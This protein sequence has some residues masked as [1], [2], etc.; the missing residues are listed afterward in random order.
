MVGGGSMGNGNVV[1]VWGDCNFMFIDGN[2]FSFFWL[3]LHPRIKVNNDTAKA[4]KANAN[5]AG[6]LLI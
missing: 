5:D 2:S 1:S 4:K 6:V 3:H